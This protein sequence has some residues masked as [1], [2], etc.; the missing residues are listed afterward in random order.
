[1]L[2]REAQSPCQWLNSKIKEFSLSLQD[3]STSPSS[4]LCWNWSAASLGLPGLGV[5]FLFTLQTPSQASSV[6]LPICRFTCLLDSCCSCSAHLLH[7]VIQ[8]NHF[9]WITRTCCGYNNTDTTTL[10][11]TRHHLLPLGTHPN[12][13]NW[14]LRTAQKLLYPFYLDSL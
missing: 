9:F 3:P 8:F 2:Q 12:P 10:A 6:S 4:Q 11:L 14:A 7:W 5:L 1:M 13:L